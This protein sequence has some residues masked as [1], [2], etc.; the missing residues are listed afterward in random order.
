VHFALWGVV[1]CL[2]LGPFLFFSSL[3]PLSGVYSFIHVIIY[4]I[5]LYNLGGASSYFPSSST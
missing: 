2:D 4:F 3:V 1:F 5:G